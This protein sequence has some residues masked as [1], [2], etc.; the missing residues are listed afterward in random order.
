MD[1]SSIIRRALAAA[2]L[3]AAVLWAA[4]GGDEGDGGEQGPTPTRE[5]SPAETPSPTESPGGVEFSEPLEFTTGTAHVEVTGDI[6]RSF[7]IPLDTEFR[8]RYLPSTDTLDI[9]YDNQEG[10]EVNA[11]TLSLALAK[12]PPVLLI[13]SGDVFLPGSGDCVVSVTSLDAQR[14]QGTFE[15]EDMESA[16]ETGAVVSATGTF[17]AE[18]SAAV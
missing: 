17:S 16:A 9:A 8:S 1:R 2:T 14:V 10:A 3:A 18:A 13:V 11:K 5:A 7:D 12:R 15:C 4:C 6:E